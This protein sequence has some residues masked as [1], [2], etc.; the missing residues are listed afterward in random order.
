MLN[1]L[2]LIIERYKQLRNAFS[3]FDEYGNALLPTTK[4]A[5]FK[6]LVKSLKTL[7]KKLY[8][9]LPIAKN[10]KNLYDV[11]EDEAE[12]YNINSLTLAQSQV[13]TAAEYYNYYDNTIPNEENK[14]HYLVNLINQ[15]TQPFT[16]TK[17]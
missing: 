7:N 8:W 5:N 6:P 1:N 12:E 9:L 15:E 4:G 11:D 3:E 16:K 10:K 14:Y 17:L 2:H 13:K